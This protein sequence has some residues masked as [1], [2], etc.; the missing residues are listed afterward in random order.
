MGWVLNSSGGAYRLYIDEVE[1]GGALLS[2]QLQELVM[3]FVVQ[4]G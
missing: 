4:Y 3:E 1:F 2:P